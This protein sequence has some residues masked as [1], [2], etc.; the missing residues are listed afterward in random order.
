MKNYFTILYAIVSLYCI[1]HSNGV[2]AQSKVDCNFVKWNKM[3]L[4][5]IEQQRLLAADNK[6]KDLYANRL[7]STK[8]Y[9][10]IDSSIKV[11]IKSIRYEFLSTV[12][13]RYNIDNSVLL[14]SNT[15]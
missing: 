1:G 13:A 12:L 5:S 2:Y 3:T 15:G 8:A 6:L 14:F 11:N 7:R 4:Q 9:W 10:E